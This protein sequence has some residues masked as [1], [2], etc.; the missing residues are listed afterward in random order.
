ML[1]GITFDGVGLCQVSTLGESKKDNEGEE[2][3]NDEP[4]L[5]SMRH[6][7]TTLTSS[8][9]TVTEQKSKLE[10]TYVSEKRKLKV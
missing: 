4:N 1:I 9:Y 5:A 3:D 7:L 8:L 6:Q 10:A 2:R